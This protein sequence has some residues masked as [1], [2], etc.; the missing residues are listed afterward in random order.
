[1]TD[2][3]LISEDYVKTH[4]GLNDN[5]FGGYLLPAIREAQDM[6]LQTIIGSALYQSILEQIEDDKLEEQ[7]QILLEEYIQIFLVY[8]TISDLIPI[9][10]SKLSNLGVVVSNDEHVTNLT[11]GERELVANH[12]LLRADFYTK[13]LQEYLLANREKYPELDECTCDSIKANL[14][15]N[16]STGLWLGGIRGKRF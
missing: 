11:Q 12:Y 6:R 2:I 13:R 16:T 9:I 14:Y 7:Y 1:M 4:S 8:Q 3:L 5:I 10:G 15:S